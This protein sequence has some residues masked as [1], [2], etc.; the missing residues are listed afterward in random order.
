MDI[1]EK[2]SEF[3]KL[4]SVLERENGDKYYVCKEDEE[5]KHLVMM[6]H[7][8]MM[9]DDYRYQFIHEALEAIAADGENAE[10]EPDIYTNELTAWLH[11][12]NSRVEYLTDALSQG[13]RD[14]FSALSTAQ[15]LEK[16]EVLDSVLTSL[17][18]LVEE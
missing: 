5:L 10:V 14:G 9:P 3:E 8:E 7:G 11:S 12:R 4:F 1:Q 17:T 6:A 2:A 15:Y 13:E 16:R 18:E